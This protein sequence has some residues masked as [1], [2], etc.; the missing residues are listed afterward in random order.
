MSEE[1]LIKLFD[2]ALFGYAQIRLLQDGKSAGQDMIF[3]RAN[4]KFCELFD[5]DHSALIG[6]KSSEL[7]AAIKDVANELSNLLNQQ[8]KDSLDR[9]FIIHLKDGSK[10]FLAQLISMES[11]VYQ[12]FIID[13]TKYIEAGD[14]LQSHEELN[15]AFI[16]QSSE[17]TMLLGENFDVRLSS[18]RGTQITGL[19]MEELS[20]F[21]PQKHIH[22]DDYA[23]F[24]SFLQD[25]KDNPAKLK[26]IQPRFINSENKYIWLEIVGSN[27]VGFPGLNGYI[28]QSKDI[29]KQVESQHEINHQNEYIKSLLSAIPDLIAVIAKDGTVLDIRSGSSL[30]LHLHPKEVLGKNIVDIIGEPFGKNYLRSIQKALEDGKTY[31]TQYEVHYDGVDHHYGVRISPLG[32]DKVLALER[33][34]SDF[35]ESR[36]LVDKHTKFQSLIAEISTAFV[37]ADGDDIGKVLEMSLANVGQFLKVHRAFIIDYNSDYSWT[38][39]L[40]SWHVEGDSG[41]DKNTVNT[42]ITS[43]TWPHN[44]LLNNEIVYIDDLSGLPDTLEEYMPDVD[45]NI[46][47]SLIMIPV[48]ISGKIVAALCFQT[49]GITRE[50]PHEEINN[51]KLVANMLGE[52]INKQ[53]INRQL[54]E[55][56]ELREIINDLALKYINL[57]VADLDDAIN[58][59]LI[60]LAQYAEADQAMICIYDWDRN[61][62]TVA[63]EWFA[64]KE[65]S[66]KRKSTFRSIDEFPLI[67]K[68]HKAGEIFMFESVA[69]VDENSAAK[70]SIVK[71]GVKSLI[72]VPLMSSG[73]CI[74]FMGLNYTKEERAIS[75]AIRQ[76][77]TLYAQLLVNVYKR[78]EMEESLVLEKEKAQKANK[79]KG[80]FLANMSHEIRTPLN[81]MV[82]F[83]DLLISS[84]LEDQQR[85]YAQNIAFSANSLLG[86][87][88]DILD[89]SKIEAEKL[90]LFPVKTDLIELV[91]RALDTIKVKA[92]EKNLKLIVN[93]PEDFPR[94]GI[95]DPLRVYQILS[96]LLSNA[97]KFTEEGEIE[98]ALTCLMQDDKDMCEL[99]FSV[100]DTGLGIRMEEQDKI[101]KEFSQLNGSESNRY[102]GTGLGLVIAS[103]LAKLMNSRIMVESSLSE[104]SIFS[105][106]V[107]TKVEYGK[108][109]KAIELTQIKRAL[110]VD[111]SK[112]RAARLKQMLATWGIKCDLL[113]Q[114]SA[115]INHIKN[116]PPYD[117]IL[118]DNETGGLSGLETI[119]Q[120]R[121]VL[122]F[123][124]ASRPIILMVEPEKA[125][126]IAIEAH[127]LNIRYTI[128][129]PI[130]APEL[131]EF[132]KMLE[133]KSSATLIDT[134]SS[135]FLDKYPELKLAFK[136]KILIAEDNEISLKLLKEIFA[137]QIPSADIFTAEDGKQA[138]LS[139]KKHAPDIILMDVQ[140]P[141]MDGI[142][143][144]REIRKLSKVP[145]IAVSVDSFEEEKEMC[146]AAGMNGF[147]AKPVRPKELMDEILKHLADLH[148]KQD[149]PQIE[150]NSDEI[151]AHNELLNTLNK[152]TETLN[153]LISI[154]QESM[155]KK[156]RELRQAISADEK[157]N[158]L[159]ILHSLKGTASNMRYKHLAEH[160]KRLEQDYKL[161]DKDGLDHRL[162][163]AEEKWEKTIGLALQIKEGMRNKD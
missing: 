44:F 131:L 88:N 149:K 25:L 156:I 92:T 127:R 145:I 143:A 114:S 89:V 56:V 70:R 138:L 101:F 91:Q 1:R 74:G 39:L 97:V 50:F 78:K 103:S 153:E 34:V 144:T 42:P 115:V 19:S 105:F 75:R 64:S 27:F 86:I 71:Y 72:L 100:R 40:A 77:L 11:E 85:R 3:E 80:T 51:L 33:D 67:A 17:W 41:I 62:L 95:I 47:L 2:K 84:E 128:T 159:A 125:N 65:Y 48:Q 158:T 5:I 124:F 16:E 155:Q 9:P 99:G 135:R 162:K 142:S 7:N 83:T 98:I 28:F 30:R 148:E 8:A 76:L 53:K 45:R 123:S 20:V 157:D 68:A 35:Y 109:E 24:M 61:I 160:F 107:L 94:Y 6:R 10:W 130:A 132:L 113:N 150:A 21:N 102:G 90:E 15:K 154:S 96:N 121:E 29:T 147:I 133:D 13:K 81:G 122:P 104:G 46:K 31:K 93:I 119:R 151:F 60:E 141:I 49:L 57:P 134:S 137:R 129:K 139:F 140:M 4:K 120:L 52:M 112:E 118:I 26:Y 36:M 163:E 59:S 58:V 63:A 146:F 55:Q 14:R 111:E 18:P 116:H 37:K 82:G 22:P 43:E 117:V 136:P 69:N 161:L 152:D 38:N 73:A 54:K 32:K 126:H 106:S 87:I 110:L 108:E 23:P 79:A 12:L 66:N